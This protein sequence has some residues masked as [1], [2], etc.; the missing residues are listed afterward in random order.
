MEDVEQARQ[1]RRYRVPDTAHDC[2][3]LRIGV[4]HELACFRK[5]KSMEWGDF[6]FLL[7]SVPAPQNH[8]H[9]NFGLIT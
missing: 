3:I 5:E 9:L 6:L 1:R 4:V 8:C 2:P 7:Q